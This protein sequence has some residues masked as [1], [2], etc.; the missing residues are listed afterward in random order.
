MSYKAISIVI[1]DF[2]SR[3]DE[4]D[5]VFV[6]DYGVVDSY[7]IKDF[8]LQD[9]SGKG[10]FE[11]EFDQILFQGSEYKYEISEY[12][13]K[14]NYNLISQG[15]ISEINGYLYDEIEVNVASGLTPYVT[16]DPEHG[17]IVVESFLNQLD[18]PNQSL[19]IAIEYPPSLSEF[20]NDQFYEIVKDFLINYTLPD[21]EI[22]FI[23]LNAS[24]GLDGSILEGMS[25]L[26]LDLLMKI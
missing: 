18:D 22:F 3:S 6:Y 21:D 25:E 19:I 1:D 26:I 16:E 8:Y 4:L 24:F 7:L 5:G 13:D 12:W 10:D 17:D 11:G 9:G 14:E 20:S 2:S 23:G 15:N